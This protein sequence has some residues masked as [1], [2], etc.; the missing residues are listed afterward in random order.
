M[1]VTIPSLSPG[2]GMLSKWPGLAYLK[3][4]RLVLNKK[5]IVLECMHLNFTTYTK[6]TTK[7]RILALIDD[8][9]DYYLS[10]EDR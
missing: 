9:V 7:Q 2:I 5:K 1:L 8:L 3:R 10:V 6:R 4:V